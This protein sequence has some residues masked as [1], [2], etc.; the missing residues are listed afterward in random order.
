MA[1]GCDPSNRD[2]VQD[3]LSWK[4]L[5]CVQWV[6]AELRPGSLSPGPRRGRLCPFRPVCLESLEQVGLRSLSAFCPSARRHMERP[7]RLSTQLTE[8]EER[9]F[10]LGPGGSRVVCRHF[11][12][13]FS[14]HWPSQCG[15]SFQSF[16]QPR[17][18]SPGR[19]TLG[20]GRDQSQ[21][22]PVL[23]VWAREGVRLEGPHSSIVSSFMQPQS[24][25]IS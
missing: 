22:G 14:D 9:W 16:C 12:E 17:F 19:D 21:R 6:R 8:A 11:C 13:Q 5:A 3:P 10:S 25:Q 4:S 7:G 1:C 15:N 23:W 2:S 24:K 18:L 20:Q